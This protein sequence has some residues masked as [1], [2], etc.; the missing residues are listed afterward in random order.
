MLSDAVLTR[1]HEKKTEQ[2]LVPEVRI[3]RDENLFQIMHDGRQN[4]FHRLKPFISMIIEKRKGFF[5]LTVDR[6]RIR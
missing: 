4:G 5:Y 6:M 1:K 3:I 2:L